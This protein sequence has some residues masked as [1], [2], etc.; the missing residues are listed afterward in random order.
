MA[1]SGRDFYFFFRSGSS[2]AVGCVDE[3]EKE[4]EVKS[5]LRFLLKK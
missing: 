4:R 1:G 5:R 3:R 2:F